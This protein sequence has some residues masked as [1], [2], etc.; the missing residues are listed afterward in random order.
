MSDPA[1]SRV[2][3]EGHILF[4]GPAQPFEMIRR[5]IDLY[6]ETLADNGHPIPQEKVIVREFFCSRNR[7][8]AL[9]RARLGFERKYAEYAAHGFQGTDPEL[10]DKITGDLET[11]MDDTFIVGSPEE[12]VE[13]IA[14]YRD[15][16]FTEI[17]LR[18][19][20]PE[21]PQRDVL[22]HIELVGREVLPAVHRL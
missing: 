2:G 22:E 5:Q 20:Y 21:T 3:R 10:S 7:D 6:H 17:S 14:A 12:C 15:L 13:Q 11:L 1:V 16:G 8:E 19:F 18:L 9:E 4:V